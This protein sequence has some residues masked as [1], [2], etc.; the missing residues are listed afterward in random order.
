[1][2]NQRTALASPQ[3]QAQLQLQLQVQDQVEATCTTDEPSR[4]ADR[5]LNRLASP[6]AARLMAPNDLGVL[7]T[8]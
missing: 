3:I 2:S 5:D 8:H 4:D 7:R 1:M 6:R